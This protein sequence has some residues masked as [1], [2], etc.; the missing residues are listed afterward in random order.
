M[1]IENPEKIGLGTW[2][3]DALGTALNDVDRVGFDW[4]YNWSERSLWDVDATPELS[5]YVAMIWDEQDATAAAL[6]QA[7]ASGATTLLGFNEPNHPGQ[8]NM[9][10]EQALALW[11]QLQASGMRLGSPAA[12][13]DQTLGPASWLGRFMAG[14]QQ[15][16]LRVDF[17]AVHYY[18]ET[19]DVAE[20]KAFLEAVHAQYRKPVWVTEWA[21]AD[22]SN[23]SR[24]SAAQQAAF[25]R[26]GTEMMDDLPFVERQAWFAA[27]EGGDGWNLNSGIIDAAGQLTLVGQTLAELANPAQTGASVSVQG[28][29]A[30]LSLVGTAGADTLVG[31]GGG[32]TLKGLAGTDTLTGGEGN[33]ILLGGQG[34]DILTGGLGAD[35]FDFNSVKDSAVGAKR[36]LVIFSQ[37]E[38]DLIDLSGID[39]SS[40]AGGN[41]A[42]HWTDTDNIRAAFSG[43]AGELRF[44]GTLLMGDTNGDKQA[45]FTIKIN[46]SITTI[47]LVL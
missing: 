10:V 36:D 38:G 8:A 35:T 40:Q 2:D 37:A 19:G 32:D 22:W 45:D 25:A 7:K 20:F 28:V 21:L 47:D 42:F 9:S 13:Q 11:P 23:P 12:T 5:S 6:A 39:A 29:D 46:G 26:A 30:P 1:T 24:F 16:G 15:Q 33:D 41:Q 34:K 17:V 18:S 27:Y 44:T 14:A 43:E 4:H 31:Q 3:K